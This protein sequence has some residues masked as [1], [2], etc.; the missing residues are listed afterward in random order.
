MDMIEEFAEGG[1]QEGYGGDLNVL[2]WMVIQDA[3]CFIGLKPVELTWFCGLR[4]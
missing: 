1:V 4:W 2:M 3:F